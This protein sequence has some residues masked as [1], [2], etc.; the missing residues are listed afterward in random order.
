MSVRASYVTRL[1]A[2]GLPAC[3]LACGGGGSTGPGIGFGNSGALGGGLGGSGY[4]AF[5]FQL[6]PTRYWDY[7]YYAR[8][9]GNDEAGFTSI[10]RCTTEGFCGLG[11]QTLRV[12]AM[13]GA[14]PAD[15][16]LVI[17]TANFRRVG[18]GSAVVPVRSSGIRATVGAVPNAAQY[19]ALR[20]VVE[21]AFLS[22]RANLQTA[23]DAASVRV[24]SGS[25]SAVVFTVTTADLQ[26]GRYPRRTGGCGRAS[27]TN[28]SI[29][30][31]TTDYAACTDWQT[32]TVDLTTPW[33]ARSDLVLRFV[34]TE[35]TPILT[36]YKDEPA[37]FL[38]RRVVLE[39]GR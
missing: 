23:T 26:S 19:Q 22:G 3:G 27:F 20:L 8:G 24:R 12:G 32:T 10:T 14:S 5:G 34:V 15:T 39:G 13:V 37:T 31:D 33:L 4:S 18:Q 36:T 6:P 9:S 29:T 35:G 30:T 1:L 7:V 2:L 38:I 25:D 11:G 16:F 21:W 17:T 28:G